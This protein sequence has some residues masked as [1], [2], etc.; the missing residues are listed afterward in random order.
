VEPPPAVADSEGELVVGTSWPFGQQL[1][2]EYLRRLML[3]PQYKI[4]WLG[5]AHRRPRDSEIN[6]LAVARFLVNRGLWG[7]SAT[8]TQAKDS[9]YRALSG[10][11]ERQLLTP[12]TLTKFIDGFDM[13]PDHAERLWATWAA[14]DPQTARAV[15]GEIPDSPG[16]RPLV[17]PALP[18]RQH[19]TVSLHEFHYLG[20]DGLPRR[21]RTVQVIRAL[22]DRLTNYPYRIDTDAADVRVIR[23]GRVVHHYSVNSQLYAFDIQLSMPLRRGETASIEY[24]TTFSYVQPPPP[25]FRRAALGWVDNLELYL[26]FDRR[27]LPERVW[28]SRWNDY[29]SGALVID[30]ERVR[31]DTEWSVHRYLHRIERTVVGFRWEWPT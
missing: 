15:T 27:R 25:E 30:E 17:D 21:H 12:E 23:G 5:F 24:E 22:V 8:E 4:K 26:Q 19:G 9:V 1:A 7:E 11:Q 28:W 10:D 29:R 31:L 3:E 18:T 2:I 6:R 14:V 13:R 20:M 16:P